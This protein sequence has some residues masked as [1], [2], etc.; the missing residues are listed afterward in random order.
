[1]RRES[2]DAEK[3]FHTSKYPV[4]TRIPPVV[5]GVFLEPKRGKAQYRFGQ[6]TVLVNLHEMLPHEAEGKFN[7][8]IS[9]LVGDHIAGN[10]HSSPVVHIM[11]A[12]DREKNARPLDIISLGHSGPKLVAHARIS[13][14]SRARAR[15]MEKVRKVRAARKGIACVIT[16]RE[17]M[18]VEILKAYKDAVA[19]KLWKIAKQHGTAN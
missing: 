8:A 16:E 7:V 19:R 11:S 6:G 3:I 17:H 9:R 5:I 13:I 15:I 2:I 12:D 14:D 1:M 18:Y 4:L 10:L